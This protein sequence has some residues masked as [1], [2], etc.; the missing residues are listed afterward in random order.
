[1]PPYLKPRE[2]AWTDVCQSV[3]VCVVHA[4]QLLNYLQV[5]ANIHLPSRTPV[6]E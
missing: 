3:C 6:R 2:Y 4:C 1:M 5:A